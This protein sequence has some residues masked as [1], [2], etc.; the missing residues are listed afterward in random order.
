MADLGIEFISVFGLPPVQFVELAAD[1]GC[2]HITTSLRRSGDYN[3][4]GYATFSLREDKVLRR[5]MLAAMR[6]RGVSPSLGEGLAILANLDVRSAYGAD[7]DLMR[8]LGVPRINVVS[9]EP[10]LSR[11]FDQLGALTEMAANVDIETVVEFV[12]IF[13]IADLPTALAAI[14]HVGRPDCRLLI[15][16]MH[17]GRSGARSSDLAALDPELIGYVQLCDAP[18]VPPFPDY[19]E[20]AMFERMVP[21]EGELPLRDILAAL[22]RD[23][24][25]GLEVPLRREAEAGIGPN[26]RM[27]RCVEAARTLLAQLPPTIRT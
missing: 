23:R 3:P 24:V 6:D 17:F 10:Q 22:P 13:T 7:L 19:L 2:R 16:T 1:L 9:L 25:I 8:E 5:E 27:G 21:G 11:T 12:P 18:R 26:K 20:E 15:D 4:H 14:R